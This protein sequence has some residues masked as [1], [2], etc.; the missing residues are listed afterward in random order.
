MTAPDVR[1]YLQIRG[2]VSP[3][4]LDRGARLGFTSSITGLPQLWAIPAE[5]GWPEQLTFAA[6]RVGGV[7]SD[8]EADRAVI[9]RDRGGNERFGLVL[10][11]DG[12]ERELTPGIDAIHALG[13]FAPDG[14]RL[15]FTHTARN[16]VDFDVAVLDLDTGERRE[17]A[18]PGGWCRVLEWGARGLLVMRARSNVDDDLLLVDPADGATT[19][20]SPAAGAAGHT[21]AAFLSDGSVLAAT[22]RGA[23]FRRLARIADGVVEPL[24][25]DDADVDAIAVAGERRAIV[26]NRAGYGRLL[27]DGEEL[28][29]LADGVAGGLAFDPAGE[30]LAFHL[31]QPADTADLWVVAEDRV[32]VASRAPPR[33]ACRARRSS[34]RCSSTSV[35]TTGSRCRSSASGPPTG[36]PSSGCMA[37]PSR[38]SGPT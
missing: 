37:G 27:L 23:D 5:G 6:E 2:A 34:R 29:G 31:G 11:E 9:E 21:P 19:V 30:R 35:P 22:D 38:S 25:T 14:R 18:T 16:G 24:G 10:L 15:A 8:A 1:A 32:P 28:A 13:A 3:V 36:P 17:P 26:E 20:L 12:V 4:W 7:I 33:A